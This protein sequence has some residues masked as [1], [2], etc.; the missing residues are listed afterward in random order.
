ML[1]QRMKPEIGLLPTLAA[2]LEPFHHVVSRLNHGE[3]GALQ[4]LSVEER[5]QPR[6][7]RVCESLGAH[8]TSVFDVARN[9][10]E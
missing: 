7:V 9:A 6:P 1:A 10:R 5:E 2:R 8:I 4:F 3:R